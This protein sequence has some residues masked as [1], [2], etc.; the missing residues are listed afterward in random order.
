MNLNSAGNILG[1]ETAHSGTGG[2]GVPMTTI[3]FN[4][5][6]PFIGN[7]GTSFSIMECTLPPSVNANWPSH[8]LDFFAD[9]HVVTP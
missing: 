7:P 2:V 1:E 3:N 4:S 6:S 5:F 9:N 8:L